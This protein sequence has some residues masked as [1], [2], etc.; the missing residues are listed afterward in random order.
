ME[1]SGGADGGRILKLVGAQNFREVAGYPTADGRRLARGLLWRSAQMDQLTPQDIET[2][3][4][5]GIKVVADLRRVAE[6]TR[7]PTSEQ[8]LARMQVMAWDLNRT[9]SVEGLLD[10]FKAGDEDHHHV[11]AMLHLY[12]GMVDSHGVQFR[13]VCQAAADGRLPILVHCAAG[14]DRTGLTIALILE[15]LGVPREY[16]LADY[17]KTETLLDLSRM[18]GAEATAGAATERPLGL[19]AA[20]IRRLFRSDPVYLE[21]TLIEL[22]ARHGSIRAFAR[23]ILGLDDA[24]VARLREQLLEA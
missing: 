20:A 24:M 22:E 8:L 7:R 19:S 6:R 12:R 10:A 3:H 9:S 1:I 11:Q 4:A 17:A 14:K 16:V 18:T 13:E 2:I 5:L 15:L 21:S 23:E